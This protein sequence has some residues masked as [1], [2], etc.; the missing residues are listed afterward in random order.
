MAHAP[1]T[2]RLGGAL[3][4]GMYN[5]N[6]ARPL[7]KAAEEWKNHFSLHH[8]TVFLIIYS[9]QSHVGPEADVLGL[10]KLKVVNKIS[11]KLQVSQLKKKVFPLQAM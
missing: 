6:T 5:I 10:N 4:A 8:K 3:A 1:P 9:W 2:N 7:I 11:L